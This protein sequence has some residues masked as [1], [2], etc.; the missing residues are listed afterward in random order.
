MCACVSVRARVCVR[1][2]LRF[3]KNHTFYEVALCRVPVLWF[4]VVRYEICP[5]EVCF[6]GEKSRFG[7]FNCILLS[8]PRS[9]PLGDQGDRVIGTIHPL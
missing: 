5:S 3:L 4:A 2:S 9:N 1:L 7:H 6:L 8:L